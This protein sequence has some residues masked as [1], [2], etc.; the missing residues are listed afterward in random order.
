[1]AM[2]FRGC[3]WAEMATVNGCRVILK[4]AP[5]NSPEAFSS[6]SDAGKA[7]CHQILQPVLKCTPHDYQIDGIT[8]AL[9]GISL[10]AILPTGAGK[11]G[12]FYMY[13]IV[14]RKLVENSALCPGKK[15]PKNPVLL[16]IC[17]T[18]YIEHLIEGTLEK[19]SIKG[20]VINAETL[21]EAR[22]AKDV[23]L[24]KVA[25][26]QLDLT[27]LIISPERLVSPNFAHLLDKEGY[28][29]RICALGVDE[30]HLLLTWGAKFPTMQAGAPFDSIIH[31]EISSPITGREFPEFDWILES[32]RVTIIFVRTLKLGSCVQGYLWEKDQV[33]VDI[34]RVQDV[35]IFGDPGDED[36][37]IQMRGRMLRKGR[38]GLGKCQEQ[39]RGRKDAG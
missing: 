31:R 10:F 29:D 37:E 22:H 8:A 19:Y 15:F 12:L 6:R 5:E 1:M 18:T 35:I 34:S 17:P 39:S 2:L 25:R 26:D 4:M 14:V 7:L 23:D 13:M 24:W 3:S 16:A 27:A 33:G 9:D 30:V 38:E 20:L 28:W 32:G 11:T 36:E 21:Q